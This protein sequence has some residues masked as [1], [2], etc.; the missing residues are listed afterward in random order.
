[1]A[2]LTE[3]LQ[4]ALESCEND[5]VLFACDVAGGSPFRQSAILCLQAPGKYFA[6]AGFNV[7]AYAEMAYNLELS[8]AELL[9]LGE[10]TAHAAIMRFPESQQ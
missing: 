9:L 5:D 2:A 3:K 6:V 4:K 8:A 1:M 7:A 10:E